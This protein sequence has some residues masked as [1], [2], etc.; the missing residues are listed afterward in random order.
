MMLLIDDTETIESKD[1]SV[2]RD[3]VVALVERDFPIIVS[4]SVVYNVCMQYQ[5]YNPLNHLTCSTKAKGSF[6]PLLYS[7][8]LTN[9]D[10]YCYDHP[11]AD[12]ML[13]VPKKYTAQWS[14]TANDDSNDLMK[15]C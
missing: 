15:K 9:T 3:L 10:W 5:S 7:I 14:T 4:R 12:T 13:F 6:K 2:S 11:T 8:N 1:Q